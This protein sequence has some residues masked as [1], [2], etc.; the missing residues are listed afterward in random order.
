VNGMESEAPIM[1]EVEATGGTSVAPGDKVRCGQDLGTSPDFSG[2][3]MCPIDGL[4]E[5]CRFDPG[6]HRFKIIIIPENGEKV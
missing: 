4:V 1:I 2:R 5:A 3:V 6:T